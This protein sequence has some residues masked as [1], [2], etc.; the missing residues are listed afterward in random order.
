LILG[1]VA[2]SGCTGSDD[3]GSG[4]VTYS[5]DQTP[6]Q[7]SSDDTQNNPEPFPD[8]ESES[9]SAAK[10]IGNADSHIFHSPNCKYVK[11]MSEGN[12]VSFNSR[13]AATSA[14]YTP[15]K[16]CGP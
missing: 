15:C 6:T 5:T 4:N 14:G 1:I 8:Q 13:D 9:V 16:V 3:Q 12:K 10:Y 7:D 11:Q 2:I